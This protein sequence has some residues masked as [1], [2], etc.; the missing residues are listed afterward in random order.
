MKNPRKSLILALLVANISNM[1]VFGLDIRNTNDIVLGVKEIANGIELNY[2]ANY[3]KQSCTLEYSTTPYYF[4]PRF[5]YWGFVPD[6][7][8][9]SQNMIGYVKLNLKSGYSLIGNQF[10]RGKNKI[11]DVLNNVPNGTIVYKFNGTYI[12]N[13]YVDGAWEDSDMILS[14]GEGFFIYLPAAT[15]ITMTGEVSINNVKS[16]NSGYNLLAIPLAIG[17][18]LSKDGQFVPSDGDVI[19]K[20]TDIGYSGTEY[21][22]GVWYPSA[23]EIKVG[24]AFFLHTTAV[25][26]YSVNNKIDVKSNWVPAQ[27]ANHWIN[28]NDP[29]LNWDDLFRVRLPITIQDTIGLVPY[30]MS[31][32]VGFFRLIGGSL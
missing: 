31:R 13:N 8:V 10:N 29:D 12:S 22:D 27:G 9:L 5:S 26:N 25:R 3:Y 16:L 6:K 18:D 24:E 4:D 2:V 20:W 11:T 7:I 19:Y 21:V 23:P 1:N 14:V 30:P 32:N 28:W 15:T 17:G